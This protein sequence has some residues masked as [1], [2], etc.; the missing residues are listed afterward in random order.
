MGDKRGEKMNID[1]L[2]KVYK[3]KKSCIDR[4][5]KTLS[6]QK[7]RNYWDMYLSNFWGGDGETW[8]VVISSR[9]HAGIDD[10]LMNYSLSEFVD[11]LGK[12]IFRDKFPKEKKGYA[13][14]LWYNVDRAQ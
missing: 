1:H 9:F 8:D 3:F 2:E 14:W 7:F 6:N 10:G 4:A 13:T 5:V 12:R 11:E